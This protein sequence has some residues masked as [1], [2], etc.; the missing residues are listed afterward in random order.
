[1]NLTSLLESLEDAVHCTDTL[2]LIYHHPDLADEGWP[3]GEKMVPFIRLQSKEA[4]NILEYL[5][6]KANPKEMI[7]CAMEVLT[8][9]E[10]QQ[11]SDQFVLLHY[12]RLYYHGNVPL[13]IASLNA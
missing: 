12:G 10:H 2:S 13:L 11:S 6:L 7:I 1:M 4:I 3:V 9:L 5:E 8:V